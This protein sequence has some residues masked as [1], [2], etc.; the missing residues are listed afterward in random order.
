M[1]EPAFKPTVKLIGKD[2]NAF[3]IL[4]SV[5][6]ALLKAGADKEYVSKYMEE[7]M[8][9]DYDNLLSVTMDYVHVT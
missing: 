5:K 4:G 3:A 9:G 6:K 1:I 2:G 7:A 8:A